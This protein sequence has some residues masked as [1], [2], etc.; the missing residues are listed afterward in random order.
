MAEAALAQTFDKEDLDTAKFPRTP[1]N[2]ELQVTLAEPNL[3]MVRESAKAAPDSPAHKARNLSTSR[4]SAKRE[5]YARV[6]GY[7]MLKEKETASTAFSGKSNDDSFSAAR[8]SS[9]AQQLADVRRAPMIRRFFPRIREQN[10]KQSGKK[11]YKPAT[12]ASTRLLDF[13][14]SLPTPTPATPHGVMD[15]SAR[16]TLS[17]RRGSI[18]TTSS[19]SSSVYERMS[20]GAILPAPN[21]RPLSL[22]SS[23]IIIDDPLKEETESGFPPHSVVEKSSG[24]STKNGTEDKIISKSP[25]GADRNEIFRRSE[26]ASQGLEKSPQQKLPFWRSLMESLSRQK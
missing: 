16:C 4:T 2:T 1:K 6:F 7:G 21:H 8:G 24:K 10:E 13:E 3:S 18:E 22:G 12:T 17:E 20:S 23:F 26:L 19:L 5:A 11:E 15:K 14:S 25:M 9:N